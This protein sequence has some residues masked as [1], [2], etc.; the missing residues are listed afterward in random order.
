M[1][2]GVPCACLGL[3]LAAAGCGGSD[4]RPSARVLRGAVRA[5]VTG[6]FPN[7][8]AANESYTFEMNRWVVDAI[9]GLDRGLNVVPALAAHWLTPDDR[10][11][12]LELRPGLRFSDGRALT[13]TDVARSLEA[14][15][16]LHWPND[17]YLGTLESVRVLDASRVE[18]RAVRPDPTLLTRLAWGFVLPAEATAARPVPVVG[19]APY[20]LEHWKP[21]EGFAFTRNPHHWGNPAAFARA[22]FRVVPE[23]EARMRL[24]ETGEV[25][26]ADF[27]PV[28]A[29]DRLQHTPGLKLVVG[30]GHRVLF[31]GL[32]VDRPPFD[33]P[34][35]REA[36][37]LAIDRQELLR[38]VFLG[39]GTLANQLMP[40]GAVGFVPDLPPSPLDRERARALLRA[41]GLGP[42][43]KIR[44]DGPN[45]RYV[46]DALVLQEVARQ[47]REVGLEIEVNAIDKNELYDLLGGA[48]TSFYLLGWASESGDGADVFEVLFPPAG[49]QLRGSSNGSGFSDARL[50]ELTREAQSTTNLRERAA[51]LRRAFK[52]LA[53]LRPILPLVVQP[54]AVVYDTRRVS[55]DPPVSLALR[56][57]DLRPAGTDEP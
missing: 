22:E 43:T 49:E 42:G 23:D 45:N 41:A 21:G 4:P 27:V 17:G 24:V 50:D 52:R 34:R 37:D 14:G 12:V 54:E 55:W 44:L 16:R 7:P 29:W 3:A 31:L 2:R 36:L 53:E 26:L 38:R 18:V 48:G 10:T 35:A 6:F 5:D 9:V 8:P 30:A 57:R 40:R 19:T 51:V 47:L 32:R 11:F 15:K 33:D 46:R 39:Q 1:G 56:P 13:A 20:E 28:D 25:D